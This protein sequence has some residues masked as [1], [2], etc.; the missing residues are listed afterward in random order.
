MAIIKG[1]EEIISQNKFATLA[2]ILFQG[3]SA[4][5][6]FSQ[7]S[8]T[9]HS[10][11]SVQPLDTTL[12]TTIFTLWKNFSGHFPFFLDSLLGKSSPVLGRDVALFLPS[13]HANF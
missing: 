1:D 8:F 10:R 9:F 2:K 6:K 11:A 5:F 3:T 7:E 12:G 4:T 13:Q